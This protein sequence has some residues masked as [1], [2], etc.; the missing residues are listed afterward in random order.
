[1]QGTSAQYRDDALKVVQTLSLPRL[2]GTTGNA[3]AAQ[4]ITRILKEANISYG[5][6]EFTAGTFHMRVLNRLFF[7]LIGLEMTGIFLFNLSGVWIGGF[8]LAIVGIFLSLR[9][10]LLI[11]WVLAKTENA[12]K[13]LN[14]KNFIFRSP[15]VATSSPPVIKHDLYFLA[16]WDSKS[17]LLPVWYLFP[18]TIIGEFLNLFFCLHILLI[19]IIQGFMPTPDP[20][21]FLWGPISGVFAFPQLFNAIGNKSPGALDDASGIAICIELQTYFQ[22]FPT[23]P[24]VQVTFVLTGMEEFGDK[25]GRNFL[26]RHSNEFTKDQSHFIVL[27][28]IGDGNTVYH[29]KH[30]LFPV[31]NLDAE[32]A[33]AIDTVIKK[34]PGRFKHIKHLYLPPSPVITDHLPFYQAGFKTLI[35]E[36]STFKTHSRRDNIGAIDPTQLGECIDLLISLVN[37]LGVATDG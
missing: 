31:K 19:V 5:I 21:V 25:G 15:Q 35:I 37:Y 22:H 8:V 33:T 4:K 27:D 9:I 6:E 3:V 16:H 34:F 17:E 32:L 30:G 23:P 13:K 24:N 26:E 12:G 2:V 11:P 10:H 7:P 29:N 20:W 18:V 14:S 36:S 1:M 28:T